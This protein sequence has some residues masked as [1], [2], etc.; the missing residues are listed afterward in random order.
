M[1][2]EVRVRIAGGKNL[3]ESITLFVLWIGGVRI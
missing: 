1:W 3:K 2:I